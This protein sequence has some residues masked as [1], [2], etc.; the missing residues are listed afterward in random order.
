[1]LVIVA[2]QVSIPVGLGQ[3]KSMRL[4]HFAAA[5]TTRVDA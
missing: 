2:G 4:L 5:P 1:M 3:C